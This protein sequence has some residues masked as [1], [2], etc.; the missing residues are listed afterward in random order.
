MEDQSGNVL[1][2]AKGIVVGFDFLPLFKQKFHFSSAQIYT[3]ELNLN[4]ETEQSPLNI[5]YII[6]IFQNDKK[7]KTPIDLNIKNLALGHGTFSYRVKDKAPTPKYFNPNDIQL[8]DIS[9]QIKLK[10]LKDKYLDAYVKRLSFVEKSGFE[11]R[12]LSFDVL[13]D[14]GRVQT[15]YL[16]VSLPQ[17]DL[18]LENIS[19]DYS[20]M[21][22][23]DKF[24]E[25]AHFNFQIKP[26][27]LL[28]KD[29]SSIIPVFS[30]F[31]EGLEISGKASGTFNN[32]HLTNFLIRNKK[33]LSVSANLNLQHLNSS[34]PKD[35][36]VNGNIN[37]SRITP[38]AIQMIA[39]N[40][41]PEPVRLPEPL[42]R[43][44]NVSIKGKISG[45]INDLETDVRFT[46]DLGEL[47]A[48][49]HFGQ[50]K[51]GFLSGTISSPGI[52]MKEL[53]NNNNFGTAGFEIRANTVFDRQ[54]KFQGHINALVKQ[55]EYKSYNY[56]NVNLSGDFTP[57]SFNG[58][59]NIDRPE[60][61]IRAEGLF[62]LQNE[63]SEFKFSATV[64]KL[65]LDKLNLTRKYRKPELS[66]EIDVDFKGDNPDNMEG[67]IA[68]RNFSFSID[69]GSNSI[70]DIVF[71]F[72]PK[73]GDERRLSIRS[74]ILNG[75]I[76]GAYS[77]HTLPVTLKRWLASYLPSLISSGSQAFEPT[78]DHF[79]MNF[80][81][82][83]TLDFSHIF[84]LPVV[85]YENSSISGEYNG[86]DNQVHLEA[87]F[88]RLS[89]AGSTINEGRLE[90]NNRN[91]FI[92]LK[93]KGEN[94][95]KNEKQLNFIANFKAMS[96]SIHSAVCWTNTD[97]NINYKGELNFITQL[98]LPSGN[99]PLSASIWVQPS[100][101]IFNDSVWTLPPANIQYRDETFHFSQLKAIHNNQHVVIDGRISR[102]ENDTLTVSL[103]DVDL[104]Y[105]FKSLNIEALTFGGTATG[106]VTVND[107]YKT[108][109]L[110]TTLDVANFSFNN[111]VFGHLG[112]QGD[113]DEQDQGVLMKG[114]I[115]K[116]DSSH[117][118]IDGIIYT[119]KE[120]L[121]I[122]FDAFNTDVSFLRKYL[123]NVVQNLSGQMSGSLY[124]CGNL[125]NPT[126]VGNAL[127]KKGSFG[128]EY[129]NTT[130]FLR[131]WEIQ[132]DSNR[133]SIQQGNIY[134]KFGNKATAGGFV[135]HNCFNNFQ[136]SA[137]INCNDFLIFNATPGINPLFYGTVFGTA[138]I[139][140]DG[141]TRNIFIKMFGHNTPKTFLTLDFMK[142]ADIV[143]YDFI[144]FVSKEK[145]NE[146][147]LLAN[148][149]ATVALPGAK[150]SKSD[151][152]IDIEAIMDINPDATFDIIMDPVT[153]DK[154]NGTGK[155]NLRI[156][157]NTQSP[158]KV[159]GKY[160]IEKGK[161]NFTIQKAFGRIFDIEENSS[162]QFQGDPLSQTKLNVKASYKL[163]AN[164]EDLDQQLT[165]TTIP[166]SGEKS[167]R[168]SAWNNV[169]VNCVLLLSG[170]LVQPAIKFD[171][172]LP[173]ATT[174]LERQV[175]SYIHTEDMMNRQALYLLVM[176]RFYT[177]PEFA[178]N[179]LSF[180]TS[181]L[182]M[183]LSSMLSSLIDNV[184]VGT[185]FHQSSGGATSRT[186]VELLLSSTLLNNRLII[187]GNFGYVNNPYLA[188]N[189]P[190]LGDFDAE[191]KLTKSGDIRLKAF[192]RYNYRNYYSLT[193]EMTQGVGIL[194]RRDFDKPGEIFRR[195]EPLLITGG[196]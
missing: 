28:L 103:N 47:Q 7:E 26:S 36:F 186:E 134:D 147:E 175:K 66:F 68:F 31:K 196:L 159:S 89:L 25:K 53:L 149:T 98:T 136:F 59:L 107:L 16:N 49:I 184:R 176:G 116:N 50:E 83:N 195:K 19:V 34:N 194:F 54:F 43:L 108:R 104:D 75:E 52:N 62:L 40:F 130:Y 158:I 5:Q 93:L 135:K 63:S 76:T 57:D 2:T 14:S 165:Q 121:S 18:R 35:I 123:D 138:K 160:E 118:D 174:E 122:R 180:L 114:K 8:S 48:N 74:N 182:S 46:T 155:G 10:E 38:K 101:L 127:M 183:Q 94:L 129:L 145:K 141:N 100:R 33:E 161:Y 112:L 188:S 27:R 87:F 137:T 168:L 17:S 32:L 125:N 1:F 106:S 132:C 11:I 191:Y 99:N 143:E 55:F 150:K 140:L 169:P 139:T 12:H 179:D 95:Q 120:E 181:S 86:L 9:T 65:L 85:L 115:F 162:I 164:L 172:E 128:I 72:Q 82:N 177:P 67:K 20:R 30:Y 193:P 44:G 42:E 110:T 70:R 58:I 45:H 69:R 153:K 3:F 22:P 77:L 111:T 79:R 60:G 131:D 117:V 73:K 6:D 29:V 156:Q 157:Y 178:R 133:I 81:V 126:V 71:D 84:E 61:S 24:S 80:T 39:N 64:S 148:G 152:Q 97:P 91:P 90:L 105:I 37:D 96:D 190:L 192:N 171:L 88:P 170:P 4:R 173:G 15:E 51:D 154:L 144:N 41:S 142:E 102:N 92:E 151:I 167:H 21:N 113:W 56:E 124:L 23:G 13:A 163:T 185:K 166:D 119:K 109:K 189:M 78:D 187:N 146:K